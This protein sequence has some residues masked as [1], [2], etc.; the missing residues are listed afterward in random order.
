V[1]RRNNQKQRIRFLTS[2][3]YALIDIFSSCHLHYAQLRE[4][5][6]RNHNFKTHCSY[7]GVRNI[8]TKIINIPTNFLRN[9]FIPGITKYFDGV[10][11]CG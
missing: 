4:I 11:F 2:L 3:F 1:V 9:I 7:I 5:K 10:K 6:M 8:L